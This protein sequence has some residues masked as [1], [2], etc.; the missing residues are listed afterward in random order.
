MRVEKASYKAMKY[1]C[2][3]FHYSKSM[4][5]SSAGYSVFNENQWCGCV[6][7]ALGANNN[8]GSE[9]GLPQGA[10]V[11]L[12]RVALN[13]KQTTTTQALSLV[14][15]VLKKQ[16]PAIRLLVS[17]ADKGQNHTGV[18]YKAL[19]WFFV[20]ETQS[21]GIEV[22]LNG[23]WVHKRTFDSL[24]N[25]PPQKAIRRKP[26]KYKY[27]YPLDKKLI[28]MCKAMAKPYPKNAAVAHK[29]ER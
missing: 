18:I 19:S 25:K 1:A 22:L 2:L 10:V 8:I 12:V 24:R 23:K 11:E 7:F 4:P 3:N 6:L 9:F 29:G 15:K 14:L 20:N 17:Y 28:P 26:G 16:N 5:S 13:G 27:I 21:S